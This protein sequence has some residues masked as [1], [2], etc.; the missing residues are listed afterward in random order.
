MYLRLPVTSN[1][2]FVSCST[3]LVFPTVQREHVKGAEGCRGGASNG[4]QCLVIT[5][6]ARLRRG[7][8]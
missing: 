6:P 2:G 8:D 7:F 5:D 1:M 3:C 4:V